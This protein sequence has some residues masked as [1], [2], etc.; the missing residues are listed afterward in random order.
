MHFHLLFIFRLP[1]YN[2]RAYTVVRRKEGNP[3]LSYS[4]LRYMSTIY[5]KISNIVEKSENLIIYF[6][7]RF[8]ISLKILKDFHNVLQN[9][10]FL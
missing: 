8:S 1:A 7:K 5:Q 9:L 2:E 6:L 3:D 4:K 10:R